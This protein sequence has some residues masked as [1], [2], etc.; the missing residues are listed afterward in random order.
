[1]CSASAGTVDSFTTLCSSGNAFQRVV[2]GRLAL[3]S[4]AAAAP[5][6]MHVAT[7]TRQTT[8]SASFVE[9]KRDR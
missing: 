5:E 1:M 7:R 3:P 6:P 2:G 4:A 9:P 8:L